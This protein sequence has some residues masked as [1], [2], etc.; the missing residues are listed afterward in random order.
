MQLLQSGDGGVSL[1]NAGLIADLHVDGTGPAAG[2]PEGQQRH[3]DDEQEDE[4]DLDRQACDSSGSA[5]SDQW[6]AHDVQR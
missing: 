2:G 4:N 1:E 6:V 3:P 5:P